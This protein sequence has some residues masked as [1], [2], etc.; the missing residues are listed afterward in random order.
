F[1]DNPTKDNQTTVERLVQEACPSSPTPVVNKRKRTKKLVF[2]GPTIQDFEDERG[3]QD[4]NQP[5]GDGLRSSVYPSEGKRNS[6]IPS[7]TEYTPGSARN[8]HNICAR[9]RAK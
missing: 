1:S 8:A 4:S 2:P 7:G 6:Q 9:I 5:D 3:S